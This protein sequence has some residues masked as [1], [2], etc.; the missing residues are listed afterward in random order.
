MLI[1]YSSRFVLEGKKIQKR[2][3]NKVAHFFEYY[4]LDPNTN[5]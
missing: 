1:Q 3:F 4:K 2:S 5:P